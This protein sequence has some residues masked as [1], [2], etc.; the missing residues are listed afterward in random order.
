MAFAWELAPSTALSESPSKKHVVSLNLCTDQLLVPLL[1]S[2]DIAGLS[3]LAG[4]CSESVVCEV[5]HAFPAIEAEGEAVLKY[6][7]THILESQWAH[8]IVQKMARLQ[9][10][11]YYQLP[12]AQKLDD[13][14]RQIRA[15]SSWLNI[16]EKGERLARWFEQNERTAQPVHP[17]PSLSAAFYS[18][19]DD[20]LLEDMIKKAGFLSLTGKPDHYRIF[21]PEALIITPP[22]LLIIS[23][24]G[25]GKSL[26]ETKLL[27]TFILNKFARPH[28][29]VIPM[30]LTLCGSLRSLDAL[31]LLNNAH[32]ALI[33]E[34]IV[35]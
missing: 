33:R 6:E 16:K 20:P 29:L 9:S 18:E 28:L 5:A 8:H 34:K 30:K 10:I 24:L 23:S 27:P 14:P 17:F 32:I 26:K 7:P 21:S 2:G 15:L 4:N 31:K 12:A 35:P 25:E 11:P 1:P 13:I 3:P 22:D 19:S